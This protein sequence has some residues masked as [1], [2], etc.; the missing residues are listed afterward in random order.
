MFNIIQAQ[1]E[2]LDA[3]TSLFDAYRVWYKK[4]SDL[5]GA[6][7]FLVGLMERGDAIAYLAQAENAEFAGFTQLYPL[8]SSTRMK[9]IWVLNDLY[10]R[11]EYRGQG[12]SKLL[13]DKAKDLA[14]ATNAVEILLE[15]GKDNEIGNRL[16]PTVGFE[17][18]T[19]FN[20]YYWTNHNR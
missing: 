19:D 7:I 1:T 6:K 10:V 3:L 17:L 15:T 16:Y 8:Y 2:H 20:F 12:V 9:R 14:R 11:P 13:I 5:E 4:P 18:N